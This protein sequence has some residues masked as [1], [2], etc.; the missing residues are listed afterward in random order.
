MRL[1]LVV[2]AAAVLTFSLFAADLAGTWKGSMDTQMGSTN[3]TIAFQPGTAL[4]GRVNAGE[5]AGSIESAK[6][7][8]QNI[9]FESNIGPGT[10]KF[11]GTVAGEQM[12][13]NVTGTQGDRYKLVCKRQK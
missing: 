12:N 3:I 13:L 2:A 10:L 9:S 4:T 5:Y 6:L 11:E 7:A 8:G 1:L